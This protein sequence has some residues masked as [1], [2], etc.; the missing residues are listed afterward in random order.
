MPDC[1]LTDASTIPGVTPSRAKLELWQRIT[2]ALLVTGYAGYYLCRSHFAVAKPLLLHE[3]HGQGLDKAV[4]GDIAFCGTL[5]YAAGKFANGSIADFVGGRR[6]FLTGMAGAILFSVLFGLSGTVP[7]FMFAWVGNR[8]LQSMGWVGTTR[9][10][11]R[12]FPFSTY[13]TAMGILSLSYL[14]GDFLSRQFLSQLIAWH[15]GW[16]HLFFAAAGVLACIF[17]VTALLLKESPTVI[18]APEPP[19]DNLF[20]TEGQ[21]VR[22]HGMADLLLPLLRSPRFWLV[23]I[24]S[25]G[26][27]V[28]RETFNDWTPTYLTKSA[29]CRRQTPAGPAPTFPSSAACPFF[30]AVGSATGSDRPGAPPLSLRH[31]PDHSCIVCS[32]GGD[33]GSAGCR[34]PDARRHWICDAWAV[35]VSRRRDLARFRRQEGKRDRLRL[36]RRDRVH[37]RQ[38][39]CRQNDRQNRGDAGLASRLRPPYTYRGRLLRGGWPVLDTAGCGDPA[40]REFRQR[41]ELAEGDPAVDTV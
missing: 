37:W 31:S 11:A 21:S 18:G 29:A 39:Y 36:D 8:L 32:F 9:L 12:R 41:V 25:F 16:R 30:C 6:M 5:A 24:L 19:P 10:T 26:F 7:L 34:H 13:G 23:C 3:F 33:A 20:G 35:C 27:T 4:L 28:L 40:D 1:R 22:P 17:I 38:Y 15:F 14:F 2:L